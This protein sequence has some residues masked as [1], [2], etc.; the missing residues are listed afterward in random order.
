MTDE[1]KSKANASKWKQWIVPAVVALTFGGYRSL[2][3]GSLSHDA[4][5]TISSPRTSTT[6]QAKAQTTST[7]Q[8]WLDYYSSGEC[9]HNMKEKAA[10]DAGLIRMRSEV[11]AA[12]ADFDTAMEKGFD[13]GC[14]CISTSLAAGDTPAATMNACRP[15]I[16]QETQRALYGMGYDVY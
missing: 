9:L 5:K 7:K 1:Q 6:Q 2:T 10:N 11:G 13:A 16:R 8:M 4:L 12:A 15:R 14:Q 3:G